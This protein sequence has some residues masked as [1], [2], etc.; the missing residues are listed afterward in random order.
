[1]IPDNTEPYEGEDHLFTDLSS[2]P[3]PIYAGSL[4]LEDIA[5]IFE[6]V[7]CPTHNDRTY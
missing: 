2:Y 6:Y 1:L 4:S 3:E 5:F 7:T